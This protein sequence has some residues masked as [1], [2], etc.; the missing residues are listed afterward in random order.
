MLGVKRRQHD[1][2]C[3]ADR[4]SC[5]VK[6][7]GGVD[8]LAAVAAQARRRF[9]AGQSADRGR[10]AP[11]RATSP[12]GRAPVVVT[13]WRPPVAIEAAPQ[14]M[15]LPASDGFAGRV[16]AQ[17]AGRGRVPVPRPQVKATTPVPKEKA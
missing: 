5:T 4:R 14:R 17:I 11:R 10:T 1:V 9:V 3:V 12:T 15:S 2:R 6:E 8:A 16:V 7:G 13:W